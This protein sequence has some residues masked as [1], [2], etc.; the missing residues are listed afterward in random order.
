MTLC[1]K[2]WLATAVSLR[3]SYWATN[4]VLIVSNFVI[5]WPS[6]QQYAIIVQNDHSLTSI[7]QKSFFNFASSPFEVLAN[8]GRGGG[9][10]TC[11]SSVWWLEMKTKSEPA[12]IIILQSYS[13]CRMQ[14]LKLKCL[15]LLSGPSGLRDLLHKDLRRSG[16]GFTVVLEISRLGNRQGGTSSWFLWA[17]PMRYEETRCPSWQFAGLSFRK[18]MSNLACP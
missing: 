5:L 6:S 10:K 16:K 17:G 7:L 15:A 13:F 12:I 14:N 2:K 8:T 4:L 9:H 11:T 1:K 3:Q 18:K